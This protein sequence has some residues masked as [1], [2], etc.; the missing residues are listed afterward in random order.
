MAN[1]KQKTGMGLVTDVSEVQTHG[2]SG[3]QFVVVHVGGDKEQHKFSCWKPEL[4]GE[5]VQGASVE[6]K[7]TEKGKWR[8]IVSLESDG[9]DSGAGK[10]DPTEREK[11]IVK[12]ACIK[13]AS[14]LVGVEADTPVD[15]A[16]E[17]ITIAEL[18]VAWVWEKKSNDPPPPEED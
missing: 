14:P 16:A 4:F 1:D 3:R 13:A 5:L 2:D 12:Q 10:E 7:Y 18:L 9:N 15:K 11:R 6:F 8:N 17:A